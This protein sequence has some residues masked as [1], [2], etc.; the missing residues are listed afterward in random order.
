VATFYLLP[1]RPLLGDRVADFLSS[2][3]PG[4]DWDS[5]M[6]TNLADAIASAA[7]VHDGVYVVFRDELPVGELPESAL[8][9][10]FGAETGDEVIEVRP[11][12][13]PG[14]LTSRRWRI[15]YREAA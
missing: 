13:T 3:L 2:L 12:T 1:P 7:E 14:G 5:G 9:D 10:G 6:R 11:A 8:A 15:G 4:L